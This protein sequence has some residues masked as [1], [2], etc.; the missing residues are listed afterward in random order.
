VNGNQYGDKVMVNRI[1]QPMGKLIIHQSSDEMWE[2]AKDRVREEIEILINE[3]PM[4]TGNLNPNWKYW[5]NVRSEIEKL[6]C[7]N[8]NGMSV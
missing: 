8:P 3:I 5:D 6:P 4:Y 7:I 1:Y 2:W